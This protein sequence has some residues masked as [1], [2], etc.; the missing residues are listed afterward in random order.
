[1]FNINKIILNLVS[2]PP[3]KSERLN[4]LVYFLP[5]FHDYT[6]S[7]N[8]DYF[9]ISTIENQTFFGKQQWY[10]HINPTLQMWPES[11]HKFKSSLVYIESL[12]TPRNSFSKNKLNVNKR[13]TILKYTCRE[14]RQWQQLAFSYQDLLPSLGFF[15]CGCLK[16]SRNVC[17]VGPAT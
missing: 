1:M 10:I 2:P 7:K 6:C 9:Y 8:K 13:K 16:G 12:R 5:F 17:K 3:Q 11:C 14:H 4:L 15:N